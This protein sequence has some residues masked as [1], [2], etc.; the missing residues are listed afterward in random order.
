MGERLG[1]PGGAEDQ[2]TALRPHLPPN[3]KR[4]RHMSTVYDLGYDPSDLHVTISEML[5]ATADQS[6]EQ[7]DSTITQVLR[8]LRERLNM[9]VVFVSEFVNGRRV[10]RQVSATDERPTVQVGESDE[11]EASWCQRVVDGRLPGFIADA[12]N[13]PA[14]AGL[15]EQL[16]FPVGTHISAPIVLKNGQVYGTL[17]SFSFSPKDNPN[18]ND[19][20]TLEMTARLT[21]M[22]LEG[23]KVAP[24]PKVVPDWSLRKD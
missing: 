12:R 17:C 11:L 19:L 15:L 10:F 22:R 5:V 6:D 18:P 2:N 4:I 20:K 14:V 16:P 8:T 21:A 1:A 7:L 9:D 3:L 24:P 23:Q 13:D